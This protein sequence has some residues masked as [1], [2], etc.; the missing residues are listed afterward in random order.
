[1]AD[2]ALPGAVLASARAALGLAVPSLRLAVALFVLF[3]LLELLQRWAVLRPVRH[4]MR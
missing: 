2:E 4:D 3:V 1:M